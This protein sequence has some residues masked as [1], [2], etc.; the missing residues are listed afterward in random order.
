MPTPHN[1]AKRG[2]FGK[3]VLMP[4]DP[5][6]AEWIAKTFLHDVQLVNTVRHINGFTGLTKNGKRI[7][8]MASGMG[9][10]SIGIYSYE[11]YNSYDVD[12]IIRIGTS[13][14]YQPNVRLGDVVLAEGCCT[15]SSWAQQYPLEGG[16]LSA[17]ANFELLNAAY[18]AAKN[19]GKNVHCGNVLSADHFYTFRKDTWKTWAKLGVLAVEMEG[20]ALYCNAAEAGKRALCMLTISDS[21]CE[22]G[23]L[24]PEQRQTGLVDM[25]EIAIEAAERFA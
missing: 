12:A 1:N 9:M 21:F 20:Y 16:T 8:V 7:S 23:I 4:G 25:I 11:L 15:D 22:E 6:R 14:S 13:G 10:P 18:E 19:Q 17:I 5:L 3:V 24:T 2:D